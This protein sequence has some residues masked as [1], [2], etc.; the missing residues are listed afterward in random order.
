MATP[1]QL[2]P[3]PKAQPRK[4]RGGRRPA[5]SRILTHTP[6]KRAIETEYEERKMRK[7]NKTQKS[8][9]TK[10]QK[11]KKNIVP[12]STKE[13]DINISSSCTDE[14]SDEY[15]KESNL[16]NV[17]DFAIVKFTTKRDLWFFVRRV[18]YELE[19]DEYEVTFL[20]RC[21][22]IYFCLS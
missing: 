8:K 19:N 15:E 3:F 12:S 6:I 14:D 5:K 7:N 21:E 4:S 17:G 18:K 9:N 16:F 10:V 22:H 2:R 11:V 13:S 1:E 20:R